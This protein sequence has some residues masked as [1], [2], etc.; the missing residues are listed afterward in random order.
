VRQQTQT[1]FFE[2]K[3]TSGDGT[4]FELGTSELRAARAA[5][6]GTYRTLFVRHALEPARR[7]LLVLPNPLE[8]EHRGLF[9]QAN[10]GVRL[11]FQPVER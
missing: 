4:E 3:A 8:P 5:R 2:V 1:L 7:Q 11:R 10:S 9:A 6:K